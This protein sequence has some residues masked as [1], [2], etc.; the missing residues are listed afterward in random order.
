MLEALREEKTW[1]F[2]AHAIGRD[3]LQ[4]SEYTWSVFARVLEVPI[5]KHVFK[6]LL[7]HAIGGLDGTGDNT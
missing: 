7:P 6:N 1:L 4:Y 3:R 2:C 5:A